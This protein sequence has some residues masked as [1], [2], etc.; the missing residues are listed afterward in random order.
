MTDSILASRLRRLRT[1]VI[2]GIEVPVAMGVR[3]RLLGLA[4]LDRDEAGSGLLI[5]RCASVHTFGVRFALDLVF[6]DCEGG[7][8]SVR[9]AVPPRRVVADRDAVA[10]LELPSEGRDLRSRRAWE[11]ESLRHRALREACCPS[12]EKSPASSSARTTP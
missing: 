1:A 4:C 3:A 12:A 9:R 6:L 10:V 2:L 7:L 8:S 11:G 5:P